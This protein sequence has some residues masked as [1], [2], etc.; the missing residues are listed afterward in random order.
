MLIDRFLEGRD[1]NSL[2]RREKILVAV[3]ANLEIGVDD[4]LDRIDDCLT[5]KTGTQNFAKRAILVGGAA[6]RDL[7]G[8]DAFLL[9]PENADTGDV[10]VAAGVDAARNID[11]EL[12]NVGGTTVLPEAFGNAL[13]NRD[14]ACGRERAI[15]QAGAGDDVGDKADIGCRQAD[16]LQFVVDSRQ[17]VERD[18]RQDKICSCATRISLCA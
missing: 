14:R 6:E 16:V 2:I 17:I 18:M 3:L 10:M 15:I 1:A 12:A 13:R 4:R 8:F 9:K 7:I 11:M 5:R